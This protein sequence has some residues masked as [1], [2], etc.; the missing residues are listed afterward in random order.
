MSDLGYFRAVDPFPLEGPEHNKLHAF[1]ARLAEG[2][3]S[4]TACAGCRR[5]AWPPRAFCPECGSDRFDWVDLP[6]EGTIHAFTAQ[7][8]GLPAGFDGPRVF[9]IVKLGGHRIFSVVT[10][11][12]AGVLKL[13]Q[14][15]RL[16]PMKVADEPKG[17]AR[18]LP[19]FTPA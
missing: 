19:A 13:G 15:V 7:D 14:R 3:L 18:W 2:R 8:T 11:A 17:G 6:H 4:T 10:G 5:T 12:D 1:Y 16:A 9:A